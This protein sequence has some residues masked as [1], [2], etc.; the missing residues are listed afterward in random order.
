M[1]VMQRA[2]LFWVVMLIFVIMLV[3]RLDEKI[4]WNWFIIFIPLWTFDILL[5][6]YVA[7]HMITHCKNGHD[8][9]DLS[10]P[11]KIAYISGLLVKLTFQVSVG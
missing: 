7:F 4:S 1:A 10:M 6:S 8:R 11:R 9:S 2:L 3:L 5:V